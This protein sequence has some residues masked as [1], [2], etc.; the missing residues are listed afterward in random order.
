MSYGRMRPEPARR[1]TPYDRRNIELRTP[2]YPEIAPSKPFWSRLVDSVYSFIKPSTFDAR[3]NAEHETEPSQAESVEVALETPIHNKSEAPSVKWKGRDISDF[4]YGEIRQIVS[5]E[6]LP[7]S[8]NRESMQASLIR[9]AKE[10]ARNH[11][12]GINSLKRRPSDSREALDEA[13]MK[14]AKV[15]F[16]KAEFDRYMSVMKENLVASEEAAEFSDSERSPTQRRLVSQFNNTLRRPSV[17]PVHRMTSQRPT[18]RD[19]LSGPVHGPI[20]LSFPQMQ[21]S[22]HD[23]RDL[24]CTSKTARSILSSMN[25]MSVPLIRSEDLGS[26]SRLQPRTPFR[27]PARHKQAEQPVEKP[28]FKL[29]PPPPPASLASQPASQT[30]K[31]SDKLETVPAASTTE[32]GSNKSPAINEPKTSPKKGTTASFGPPFSIPTPE[33]NTAS[34]GVSF[35]LPS[36]GSSGFGAP[37]SA[38]VSAPSQQESSLCPVC[39]LDLDDVDHSEC[40]Q[41]EAPSTAPASCVLKPFDP[42]KPSM[43]SFQLPAIQDQALSENDSRAKSESTPK[44]SFS[45]G[46]PVSGSVPAPTFATFV[47]SST[48]NS[49]PKVVPEPSDTKQGDEV[50]ARS[51]IKQNPGTTSETTFGFPKDLEVPANSCI[52]N[53]EAFVTKRVRQESNTFAGSSLSPA[54]EQPAASLPSSSSAKIGVN[55]PSAATF[56]FIPSAEISKPSVSPVKPVEKINTPSSLFEGSVSTPKVQPGA[57]FEFKPAPFPSVE[58]TKTAATPAFSFGT[59]SLASG[60][61]ISSSTPAIPAPEVDNPTTAPISFSFG[62]A[63]QPPSSAPASFSAP[64]F[65]VGKSVTSANFD[66]GAGPSMSVDGDSDSIS[67]TFPVAPA[68]SAAS[69]F[70]FSSHSAPFGTSSDTAAPFG[71]SST[72]AAAPL[73]LGSSAATTAPTGAQF[74]TSISAA[75]LQFGM[76]PSTLFGASATSTVAPTLFGSQFDS[77][78]TAPSAGFGAAPASGAAPHFGTSSSTVPA[79]AAAPLFGTSSSAAPASDAAPL[80]GTST[81]A[82]PSPFAPST[83]GIFGSSQQSTQFAFNANNNFGATAPPALSSLGSSNQTSSGFE[84]TPA[85]ST[86]FGF[87]GPAA[88]TEKPFQFPSFQQTG[89]FQPGGTFPSP[90]QATPTPAFQ[91]FSSQPV[92]QQPQLGQQQ[93]APAFSF[94]PGAEGLGASF[95]HGVSSQGR[96]MV[97]AKRSVRKR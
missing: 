8:T 4:T 15:G 76:T 70:K 26:R 72:A 77:K 87:G 73:Q 75:P 40:R 37:A 93:F 89:Q 74:G 17:A 16:S 83:G 81:S 32:I 68:S 5:E 63:V 53:S 44:F 25:A 10:R 69:G 71:T 23:I 79:S 56:A 22:T 13:M 43:F 38:N 34:S 95:S 91:G 80:F 49:A 52:K 6:G 47:T 48:Q 33:A 28:S 51:Q 7:L 21:T 85:P 78:P 24:S 42:S 67:P 59:P 90:A 60:S 1:T 94:E 65:N 61:S 55:Q 27:V 97:K 11:A 84:S 36:T 62:S 86:G 66:S 58:P 88:S 96:A 12:N 57:A 30:E 45:S 9:H 18:R 50:P 19:S 39:E 46:V 29:R 35:T 82:S 3:F 2:S 14:K 31:A 64:I 41:P 20:H 54:Q 92:Q